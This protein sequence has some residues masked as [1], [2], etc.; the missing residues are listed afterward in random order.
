MAIYTRF[1]GAVT[2]CDARL[3]PVWTIKTP[4][5]FDWKYE[6]PKKLPKGAIVS[7]V[8]IWHYRGWYT[9]NGNPVCDNKW[10]DAPSLKADDGWK[11]IEAKLL[12]LCPD[13]REKYDEWNKA[14]APEASHFFPTITELEAA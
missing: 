9:D 6:K 8:P 13:G 1:G 5:S 12:E 10:V 3:I 2:L 14:G 7:E 11:E 4:G